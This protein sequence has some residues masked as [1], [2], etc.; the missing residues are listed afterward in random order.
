MTAS[1][2][3]GSFEGGIAA[4]RMSGENV[5]LKLDYPA[6]F[7]LLDVPLPDGHTAILDALQQDRLI[8]PC[9]AGGFDITNV[10][11]V[12]LARN[13]GDFRP[14]QRKSVRVIEYRGVLDHH[15][16]ETWTRQSNHLLVN[17]L[18]YLTGT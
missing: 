15:P 9:A 8:A 10:G 17:S 6:Y 2:D 18:R 13:L 11:A 16:V 4:E 14:L 3:P 7:E 12:L 1:G 5:L